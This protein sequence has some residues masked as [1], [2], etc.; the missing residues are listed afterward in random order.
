MLN[1]QNFISHHY[2]LEFRIVLNFRSTFFC[3]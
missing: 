3:E 1:S 2:A